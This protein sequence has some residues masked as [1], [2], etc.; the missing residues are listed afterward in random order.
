MR[1]ELK[2]PLIL[3]LFFIMK[4]K[5]MKDSLGNLR[6]LYSYFSHFFEIFLYEKK[7]E[8]TFPLQVAIWGTD[9]YTT[10]ISRRRKKNLMMVFVLCCVCVLFTDNSKYTL[11]YCTICTLE[12]R[13]NI[14]SLHYIMERPAS[15]TQQTKRK[16]I[17]SKRNVALSS[18]SS[19]FF[20]E[21]GCKR[22]EN[23]KHP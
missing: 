18:S 15:L 12:K 1:I 11:I 10:H 17:R 20:R 13:T 9:G 7:G 5:K 8:A 4:E 2:I 14:A 22:K 6:N 16:S 23:E 19:L 21:M 3:S